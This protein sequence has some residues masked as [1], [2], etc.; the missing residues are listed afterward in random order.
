MGCEKQIGELLVP[1]MDVA[2]TLQKGGV[3]IATITNALAEA[4]FPKEVQTMVEALIG[5]ELN[6]GYKPPIRHQQQP[7]YPLD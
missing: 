4:G 3:N 2:H 7:S 1:A 6:N 5:S